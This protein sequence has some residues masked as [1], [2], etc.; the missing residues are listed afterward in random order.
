MHLNQQLL[1]SLLVM[2][3]VIEARDTYTGGHVW[4]VSQL[5]KLLALRHGLSHDEAV[6]VSICGYLHDLGK[7]GIS[8]SILLKPGRL[9]E[10]QFDTI[11]THPLIGANLLNEHPL[12]ELVLDV[13]FHHHERLD[14]KGYPH[15]LDGDNLSLNAQI[16]CLA[17]AFDA[18]T[19]SRP[20]RKGAKI[21][22]AFSILM[23]ESGSQFNPELLAALNSLSL[24]ADLAH[25]VGH[26]DEG[27]PVMDCP[28]CGAVLTLT[29]QTVDGDI[30][31]CRTCTGKHILH[32]KMDV[33]EAE[34]TGTTGTPLELLPLPNM[35]VI[36]DFIKKIPATLE[37]KAKM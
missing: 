21:A 33:F 15:G 24:E 3:D 35:D 9:D 31:Y 30:A 23:K 20:Y 7:I 26:S 12:G 17:D 16:I 36:T 5:A 13:V 18:L 28:A 8:D 32:K 4:R 6:H 14:G 10:L 11:K 27:L 2:G 29:R 37:V 19:S 1:R 25:I 22:D 34:F